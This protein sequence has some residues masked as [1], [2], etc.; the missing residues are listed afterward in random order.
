MNSVERWVEQARYD[1][2]TARAM[3]GSGG[4]G[5]VVLDAEVRRRVLDAIRVLERM[6]TVRGVYVFGSRAEGRGDEWS[7]IDLAVFMDGVEAWDIRRRARAMTEVQEKA[8]IDI[9]AHLFST[10]A[11]DHP[12]RGSFAAYIIK[13]GVAV[14]TPSGKNE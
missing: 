1:L 9:E 7:D 11:L 10:S 6:A 3:L 5:M 14:L 2:D 4:D 8:G 12:E 13:N